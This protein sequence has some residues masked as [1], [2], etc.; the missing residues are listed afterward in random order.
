MIN[1]DLL[2]FG[3]GFLDTGPGLGVVILHRELY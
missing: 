1:K 2:S 3:C